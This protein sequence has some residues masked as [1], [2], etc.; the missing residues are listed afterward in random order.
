MFSVYT[1]TVFLLPSSI[2]ATVILVT[3]PYISLNTTRNN[4]E[5]IAA[6]HKSFDKSHDSIDANS[7]DEINDPLQ[8]FWQTTISIAIMIKFMNIGTL[9]SV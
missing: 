7:T 8:S 1:Y 9:L 2:N 3:S 6:V 5:H 4:L